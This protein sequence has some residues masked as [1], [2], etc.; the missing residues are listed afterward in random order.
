VK[1]YYRIG[2]VSQ[3]VGVEPHVLRYWESEFPTIRP[4]K[5]TTGQRVYSQ[6]DV[7]KLLRIRE[8]LRSQ[9]FTIAGAR[10]QLRE[11]PGPAEQAAIDS[12]QQRP[13]VPNAEGRSHSKSLRRELL[14][15]RR[16]LLRWLEE[17]PDSS[18]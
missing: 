4:Q 6:Q 9:G 12:L 5:S 1:H 14:A 3:L 11:A 2:E 8:L 15:L 18:E 10:R 17:F 7:N 16:D 13:E